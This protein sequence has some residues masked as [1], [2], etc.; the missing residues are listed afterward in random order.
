MGGRENKLYFALYHNLTHK[1]EGFWNEKD[2]KRTFFK[3]SDK[4]QTFYLQEV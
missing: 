3:C 2:Q 1:L 4:N